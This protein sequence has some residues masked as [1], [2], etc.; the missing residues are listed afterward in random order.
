M[1]QPHH[2]EPCGMPQSLFLSIV[3]NSRSLFYCPSSISSQIL[4]SS[5][6]LLTDEEEKEKEWTKSRAHSWVQADWRQINNVWVHGLGY[7]PGALSNT[8]QSLDKWL[9]LPT[10]VSQC[11]PSPWHSEHWWPIVEQQSALTLSIIAQC[12]NFEYEKE[13][14]K[15]LQIAP[16]PLAVWNDRNRESFPQTSLQSVCFNDSIFWPP[17]GPPNKIKL[18][19]LKLT[20]LGSLCQV[21]EL[22]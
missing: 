9:G 15:S 11:F 12:I 13:G 14:V 1:V 18:N 7:R 4:A 22:F 5:T 10:F 19:G 6:E 2:P 8:L 3:T 17:Y 16:F 20:A 21:S